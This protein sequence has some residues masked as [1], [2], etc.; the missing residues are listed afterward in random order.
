MFQLGFS[1]NLFKE[2][3]KYTEIKFLKSDKSLDLHFPG[4]G[5]KYKK[6]TKIYDFHISE[7][8]KNLKFF[9]QDFISFDE[10]NN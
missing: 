4:H 5:K 2:K 8:C 10:L 9:N 3:Q 1:A 6:I 7:I